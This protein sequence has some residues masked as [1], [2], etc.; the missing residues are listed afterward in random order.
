MQSF[1]L[2]N[3]CW[4]EDADLYIAALKEAGALCLGITRMIAEDNDE[5]DE[6]LTRVV[7]GAPD[8]KMTLQPMDNIIALVQYEEDDKEKVDWCI[9]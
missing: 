1:E 4:S 2:M 7:I 6:D 3:W 8:N 9:E 5:D